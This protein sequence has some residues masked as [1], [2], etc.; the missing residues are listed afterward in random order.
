MP[1]QSEIIIKQHQQLQVLI[2]SIHPR[3]SVLREPHSMGF[4]ESFSYVVKLFD[5]FKSSSLNYLKILP[6]RSSSLQAW[7]EFNQYLE[8]CKNGEAK[9]GFV[10]QEKFDALVSSIAAETIAN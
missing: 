10:L 5:L 4:E 6:M 1:Y 2:D 3:F 7:N 9:S 8:L